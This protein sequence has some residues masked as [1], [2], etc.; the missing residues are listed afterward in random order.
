MLSIFLPGPPPSF[1]LL[2]YLQN[3]TYN[4]RRLLIRS[5]QLLALLSLRLDPI[6]LIQQIRKHLF[7]IQLADQ[8]ILD[9]VLAVV[10]EQVHDGFGDLVGDAFA[11]DVEVG[12]YEAADQ[13]RF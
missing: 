1:L 8:P 13:F 7:T 9:D 4:L 3:L 11:H 2:A 10:H 6:V 12:G 5:Q